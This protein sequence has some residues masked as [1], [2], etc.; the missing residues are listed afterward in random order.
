M[1]K[2]LH[3]IAQPCGDTVID[4]KQKLILAVMEMSDEECREIETLLDSLF[5]ISNYAKG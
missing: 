3:T 4:L 1:T 5:P 2:Q